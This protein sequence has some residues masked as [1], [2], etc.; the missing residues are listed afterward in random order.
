M[1]HPKKYVN[2]KEV[3][4]PHLVEEIQKYVQ[5]KHLYIPCTERKA[6]GSAT[7]SRE[8][9]RERNRDIVRRYRSGMNMEQL[10]DMFHLSVERIESIVYS[11]EI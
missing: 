1:S 11:S 3:L 2:A 9:L 7:G 4:P 10:A 8:E 6:W 5:G